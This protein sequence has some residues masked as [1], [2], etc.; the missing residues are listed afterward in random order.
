MCVGWNGG[1]FYPLFQV[2]E[3]LQDPSCEGPALCTG[4]II[5]LIGQLFKPVQVKAIGSV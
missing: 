4:A 2:Y 3:W 1:R 5:G